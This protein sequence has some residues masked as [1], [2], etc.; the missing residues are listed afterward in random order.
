MSV[1][2]GACADVFQPG[3]YSSLR[4]SARSQARAATGI[5]RV[6]RSRAEAVAV[7]IESNPQLL[8]ASADAKAARYDVRVAAASRLPRLSAVA[9]SGYNNYLGSLTSRDRKS[10]R[11]NS[12]H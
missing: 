9:S 12:S 10:T 8:A 1:G 11:L 2:D 6:A 4:R 7:D 3:E 5:A